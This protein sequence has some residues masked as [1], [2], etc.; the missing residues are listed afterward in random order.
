MAWLS[1]LGGFLAVLMSTMDI[2][3]TNT[4]IESILTSL[5]APLP[6]GSWLTSV[7][8]IAE[9]VTLPLTGVL[10]LKLG[11]KRYGLIFPAFFMF[12]SLLCACAWNVESLVFFRVLQGIAGGALAP[13]SY[14][15]I[16][17]KLPAQEH[18]KAIGLFG[19]IVALAPTLGPG[20]AGW[21]SE[22]FGW[23]MLFF[24]NIPI[25]MLA[26][27]LL[28]LGLKKE[29]HVRD[30]S[31][32]FNWLG[33][34][35]IVV[36][37]GSLQYVLERGHVAHW[38]E[39][40]LIGAMALVSV[41]ALSLF[42]RDALKSPHPLINLRLL[43]NPQLLTACVATA[44]A[45]GV[46]FASYFLI[47]YFL[48]SVH[49]YTPIQIGQ[50]ILITGMTQLLVLTVSPI[51]MARV[52][53]HLVIVMGAAL[54]ACANYLWASSAFKLLVPVM[55]FAQVLRGVGHSL[56]L[57][58]LCVAATTAID[59]KDASSA[60]IL[61]N[62]SRCL[63]GAVGLALLTAFANSRIATQMLHT[64]VGANAGVALTYV[65]DSYARAFQDVFTV[66]G[67]VFTLIAATFAGFYVRQRRI[68]RAMR[69]TQPT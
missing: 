4:A 53:L 18:P 66:M 58:P 12:S 24:M 41:A 3:I 42:V 25:G 23:R 30:Q 11:L 39:S 1:V 51:I 27:A 14:T 15:L 49:G 34:G 43:R 57:A 60:A 33:V 50:V 21:I 6:T 7:Y 19:A 68:Q 65:Q 20:V 44:V 5:H 59:K 26:L 45:C 13:F 61:F 9:I 46:V 2:Q 47:P 32:R 29:V 56:V 36:G 67:G 64:T 52:R 35:S 54:F 40:P 17:S 16:I 55:V 22:M 37:L 63:G 48:I 10:T 31:A 69:Y 28:Y 38:F 62:V 8:L